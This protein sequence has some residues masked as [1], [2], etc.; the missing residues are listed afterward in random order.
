M[1]EEEFQDDYCNECKKSDEGRK[2]QEKREPGG[3][4]VIERLW[5]P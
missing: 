2:A 3:T 1:E 4:H 5:E